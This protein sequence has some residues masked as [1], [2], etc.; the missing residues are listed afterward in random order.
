MGLDALVGP[1]V[2]LVGA[3]EATPVTTYL[4]VRLAGED[5]ERS[6]AVKELSRLLRLG[7]TDGAALWAMR[8]QQGPGSLALIT[9]L[10]DRV[11]LTV[12]EGRAL[13]ERWCV[14]EEVLT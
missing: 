2:A 4:A 3:V 13:L 5:A 10:C 1:E 12:E 11:Q 6:A 8:E 9:L 14:D 7:A